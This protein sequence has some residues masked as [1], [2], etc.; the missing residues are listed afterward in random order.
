MLPLRGVMALLGKTEEE[1]LTMVEDG[2]LR[3]V[4]NIALCPETARRRELRF[5]PSVIAEAATGNP[6]KLSLDECLIALVP[7]G[8][9]AMTPPEI[10]FVL[11][12]GPQLVRRL[13]RRGELEVLRR[14]RSGPG[15]FG[16]ARYSR[17]SLCGF[18][19]RRLVR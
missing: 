11:N 10:R 1:V 3:L 2:S 17:Q 8:E 6:S 13:G 14:G 16:G 5:L 19:A 4:F 7:H 18:L 15:C 12:S 9:E